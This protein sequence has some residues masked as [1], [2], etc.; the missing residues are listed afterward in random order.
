[1]FGVADPDEARRFLKILSDA[2]SESLPL[3]LVMAL[4]SDFLGQL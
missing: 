4:R 1:L 2:L 3:L